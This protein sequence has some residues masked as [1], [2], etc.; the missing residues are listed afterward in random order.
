MDRTYLD[1]VQDIQDAV[2]KVVEFTAG[3]TFDQFTEDDKTVFA[4]IRALEVI[5]EAAKGVPS[6]IRQRY[7]KIPWRE[8]AGMRDKLVHHYFGVDREVVWKTA[9][10]QIPELKTLIN[11]LMSDLRE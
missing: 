1:Y 5:G 7:P 8:M 6:G 3:M 10:A 9:T 11:E 4:V 2:D